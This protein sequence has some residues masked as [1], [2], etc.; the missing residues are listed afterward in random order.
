MPLDPVYID[1]L[2]GLYIPPGHKIG[3][4]TDYPSLSK[5]REIRVTTKTFSAT[6][7]AENL[8]LIL[9]ILGLGKNSSFRQHYLVLGYFLMLGTQSFSERKH[10]SHDLIRSAPHSSHLIGNIVMYLIQCARTG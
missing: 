8:R 2:K 9:G 5:N 7:S 10:A 1:T 4:K 3:I 6:F